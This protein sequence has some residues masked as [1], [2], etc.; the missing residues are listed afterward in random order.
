[1]R[2]TEEKSLQLR[3]RVARN[4]EQDRGDSYGFLKDYFMR[5]L[6]KTYFGADKERIGRKTSQWRENKRETTS[7]PTAILHNP[8]TMRL[9]SP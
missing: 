1:M 6:S 8:F 3:V 7:F 2:P 4:P 5:E 9:T